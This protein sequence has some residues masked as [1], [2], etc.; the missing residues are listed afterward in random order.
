MQCS[1]NK[2]KVPVIIVLPIKANEM[3][4]NLKNEEQDIIGFISILHYVLL[5]LFADFYF[6]FLL[7]FICVILDTT[8]LCFVLFHVYL[9]L[10]KILFWYGTGVHIPVEMAMVSFSNN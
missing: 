3:V 6:Y 2:I 5:F 1:E 8:L 7:C 9:V 4:V 10:S